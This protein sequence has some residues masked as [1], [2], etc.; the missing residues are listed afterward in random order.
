MQASQPYKNHRFFDS[1][2]GLQ[3]QI[4]QWLTGGAAPRTASVAAPMCQRGVGH[5]RRAGAHVLR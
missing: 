4:Q 5:I 3:Q 2:R 1:S